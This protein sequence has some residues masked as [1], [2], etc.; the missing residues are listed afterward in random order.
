[1]IPKLCYVMRELMFEYLPI[2]LPLNVLNVGSKD[3]KD[4]CPD[5]KM[6]FSET[7][8]NIVGIDLERGKDVDLV[9]MPY[10]YPFIDQQFDAV[11]SNQVMEHV[12]L[13]WVWVL[14]MAR[15]VRVDGYLIISTT[16]KFKVHRWPVDCWRILPDGMKTILSYANL[17]PLVYSICDTWTFGVGK[18][19]YT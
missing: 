9:S 10:N 14:E 6:M 11:I 15:L 17:D 13:F 4:N 3:N 12:E 5:F 19:V 2:D 16:W 8:W 1:M 7:N 18:K